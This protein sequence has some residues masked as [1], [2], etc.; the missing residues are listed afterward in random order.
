MADKRRSSKLAVILHADVAGSTSLVQQDEHLAHERIL[1][2]FR[3]CGDIIVKY[4]GHVQELRGD[5]L[6]A[7]FERASDAVTAALAFQADQVDY[8]AQF[9]DSI[10]PTV[11]IGIAMG[12]VIIADNTIT[13]A[14]V[15]LAQRLE[16]LATAGSVCLQGAAYETIPKR[17][18]FE[19][20]NLGEQEFKGFDEPV[21]VYAVTL[22]SAGPIP[23]PEPRITAGGTKRSWR[24]MAGAVVAILV[25]AGGWLAWWQPWAVREESVSV[26]QMILPLP[27][28]SSVAILAFE[29]L[30][31]DPS[32]AYFAD[33][34][35]EDL[36]TNLSLY[37]ELFVIARNSAFVYKGKAVDV[38]QIGRELGVAF[39]VEGSVR[40]EGNRVRIN[41]Q[42]IDARSG[43][44]VWAE[45]FDRELTDVFDIQDEITRSIAGRLAPE[46][47]RARLEA[48]RTKPTEDLDAWDLHLQ[49]AAATAEFTREALARAIRLAETAI[50]RD[51]NFAAPHIVIARA[52]GWQYFYRW[53]DNP[54]RTLA[55]AIESAQTAIRLD[56]NDAAGYAALG[57][58]HRFSRNETVAVANL[59]RAVALNPNDANI[60]LEF[61]HTLD[62]FRLQKRARP[63]ILEAIR[64]SPRDPRLQMMFF[65]KAHILFHLRDYEASLDAAKEMSSALT[66]DPWRG[67]YHLVRAANLAELGRAEEARAEVENS[68]AINPK[69]SLAT[70]RQLFNIANNHPENRRI[71]LESLR[72]AGMPIE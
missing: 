29:N 18:P 59:E 70:I 63:Q 67:N 55:E 57:Y 49:A 66:S 54:E 20:E 48:T 65:F 5:A 68:R 16:Q 51:V 43:S 19:Y 8:N 26:E 72:K 56:A 11:R 37:R 23:S 32:Q 27:E 12:E 47:A 61:A 46:I 14:G 40:R 62:W 24:T 10:Q 17:L 64:L 22:T 31:D 53:T 39:V 28:K 9:N 45:R 60:R 50:A 58:L 4:H 6:L 36:T 21:R 15:V 1:D 30:G 2:T 52:K 42:L 3:R 13:G 71:W 41:A 7:E 69:L 34:L 25:I 44:H 38:K 33:G 35:T